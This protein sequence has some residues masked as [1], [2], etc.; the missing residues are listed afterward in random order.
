MSLEKEPT[1]AREIARFAPPGTFDYPREG[2][3]FIEG[4]TLYDF[5]GGLEWDRS[6]RQDF[7]AGATTVVSSEN[8]GDVSCFIPDNA[9]ALRLTDGTYAKPIGVFET[10]VE[11][12]GKLSFIVLDRANRYI[13]ARTD[14]GVTAPSEEARRAAEAT[15]GRIAELGLDLEKDEED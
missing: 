4:I 13:S 14:Q 6:V 9:R 5:E 12:T 11:G 15:F 8:Y 10:T 2:F 3:D 7:G 1:S